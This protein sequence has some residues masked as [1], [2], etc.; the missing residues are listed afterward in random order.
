MRQ[1]HRSFRLTPPSAP[2][3][4]AGDAASPTLIS[5]A[6]TS[7]YK[8]TIPMLWF[9]FIAFFLCTT[10]A[11]GITQNEPVVEFVPFIVVP[12]LLAAFGYGLMKWNVFDLVNEVWDAGSYLIVKNKDQEERIALK[13]VVNVNYDR[14]N[15]SRVTLVL[16][17]PSAFGTEISFA[18]PFRFCVWSMPPIARDLI[19]RIDATRVQSSE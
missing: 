9:G 7:Y 11:I 10:L 13:D 4:T 18:P 17:E 15:S 8:R 5:S 3:A 1:Q 6:S 19:Q 12:L 16:R 14:F 2:L